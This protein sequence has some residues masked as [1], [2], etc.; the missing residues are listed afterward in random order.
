MNNQKKSPRRGSD[1]EAKF[2][3]LQKELG[4]PYDQLFKAGDG[5]KRNRR[6]LAKFGE[7]NV[8]PGDNARYLRYALASWNLPPIDIADEKQVEKRIGEYFAFCIE[9]DRKP[10]MVGM[11]NWVGV[12]KV[13]LNSWKRGDYR[14]ETHSPVIKKACGMLEELWQ[15]YMHNGKINPASGIFLGKNMFGYKDQ[16]EVVV[17][18]NQV[19]GE[20]ESNAVLAE[21]YAELITDGSESAQ[22]GSE[23]ILDSGVGET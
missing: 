16:Q 21:K 14:A 1:K 4:V 6:D 17:T 2:R 20:P 12:D 19:L 5:T 11:A 9:N 22:N 7:E 23:S 18:P 13:T 8:Q 3:E 10:N 15:D